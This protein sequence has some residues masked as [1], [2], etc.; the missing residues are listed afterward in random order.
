M[1]T[2]TKILLCP[3]SFVYG[4]VMSVRN[5]MYDKGIFS[6]TAF[7]IPIIS[8]GN[9]AV[10]GT[11]KTP[12]A[13][14]ILSILQHDWKT[15]MLSRGYKRKTKGFLLAVQG[16]SAN[17]IGDEPYQ[18]YR[19]FPNVTV[20]VDKKR[21]NGVRQLLSRQPGLQTIVLDDAFQHRSI[22]AGLSILLTDYPTLYTRDL[23]LP[24]GRL[25]EWK[26]G[27]RRADIIVVTKCPRNVS[28]DEI[29][30]ELKTNNRQPIFFSTFVYDD[31]YPLF[32]T[33]E[34]SKWTNQT[35]KAEQ[36]RIIVMT[37]IVSP[38]P[39]LEY[40]K[41]LTEKIIPFS[42]GDHHNFT[43]KDFE[44][45]NNAYNNTEE[46]HKLIIVTEKDASRIINNKEFPEAL[47]PYVYVLPV[48]IEFLANQTVFIQKIKDYVT[49]NSKN[50]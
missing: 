14:F 6:S 49:E 43:E 12:H 28:I 42:F 20:A 46:K 4:C 50:S 36:P 23:V 19:K 40:L 15:A 8:I 38:K 44:Q 24:A 22:K 25:R 26:A 13:E 10:G 47:K 34:N 33:K 11:G 41:G 29:V 27:S 5:W 1:K 32:S 18:I 3:F 2:L 39:M 35:I 31:V 21:V 9:L 45:L 16:C 30:K 37:G 48:R 17:D 7:D